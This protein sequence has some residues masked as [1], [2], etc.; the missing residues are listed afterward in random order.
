VTPAGRALIIFA[1]RPAPGHVKTRLCPP[2]TSLQAAE[3]YHCMLRDVVAKADRL[4]GVTPFLYYQDEPAAA[5]FFR[6]EFPHLAN[7]PQ[8]GADLGERMATAFQE[9]FAQGFGQ[10]AIIG[11]DL[12]DL[13]PAYIEQ[14]FALLED[15]AVDAVYGPSAD[16][17]Y[18]LLGLKQ[19]WP[20][21]FTD[22]P[23]STIAVLRLSLERAAAAGIRTALVPEWHDVDTVADLQREELRQETNDAA[24]T[25][26]F[27]AEHLN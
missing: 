13:P 8:Q 14:A 2:L 26:A 3:L 7:R 20:E 15:A 4:P 23:W 25:R 5:A 11:T 19:L 17:G 16:G 21:L 27:I 10:V 24:L 6:A 12:P 22:I 18:Y 1:K 9:L